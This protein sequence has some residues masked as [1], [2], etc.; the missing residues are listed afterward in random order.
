MA[1]D[2]SVVNLWIVTVCRLGECDPP[3]IH[4]AISRSVSPLNVVHNR[5]R[6][7]CRPGWDRI[8]R[9]GALPA[10][11]VAFGDAFERLRRQDENSAALEADPFLLFPNAQL[12]V[13]ALSRHADHIAELLLRDGSFSLTSALVDLGM[14]QER[15]GKPTGEMQKHE[16]LSLLGGPPQ[17]CAQDLDQLECNIRLLPHQWQE[18][19]SL[20]DEQFAIRVRDGVRRSRTA[21]E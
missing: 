8:V 1:V 3:H 11:G 20:D 15:F 4:G 18:I 10:L 19:P 2:P 16:T 6:G 14:P 21:V 17:P 13:R 9:A 7:R 12:T 5:F